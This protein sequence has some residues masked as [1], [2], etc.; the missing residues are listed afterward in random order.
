MVI[1]FL[2]Q[3]GGCGKSSCC[4]H[5]GGFLSSLG[6]K[7]LLVDADMEDITLRIGVKER[8]GGDASADVTEAEEGD[9]S[10]ATAQ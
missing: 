2:N 6:L 7:T 1:V 10:L 4:F 9:S 8:R 3:K 5:L